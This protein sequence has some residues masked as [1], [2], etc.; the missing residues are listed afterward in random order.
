MAK[1]RKFASITVLAAA[2][3]AGALG[4]G[5]GV[6]SASPAFG[7]G[8]IP[9]DHGWGGDDWDEH[10]GHGWG[11]RGWD[12]Y[13]GWGGPGYFPPPCLTVPYVTICA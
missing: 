5:S 11:G 10:H 12:G 7:P 9:M 13:T 6:A 8:M 2:L 1:F 4:I 3:G